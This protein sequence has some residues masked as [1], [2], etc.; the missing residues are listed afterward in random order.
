MTFALI[1]SLMLPVSL[2][3]SQNCTLPPY[4]ATNEQRA[5]TKDD[6]CTLAS[7]ACRM[8]QDFIPVNKVNSIP[9]T[10]DD[11]EKRLAAKCIKQCE[12]KCDPRSVVV[13]C[14]DSYCTASKVKLV[15]VPDGGMEP[16]K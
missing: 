9:V 16:A 1:V 14:V 4:K 5:C 3:Q 12:Q 2:G 15:A 10:M 13:K 11:L 8:C 6:D 7:D